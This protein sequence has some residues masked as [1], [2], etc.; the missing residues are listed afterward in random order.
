[1]WSVS[2]SWT[3]KITQVWTIHSKSPIK[4]NGKKLKKKKKKRR[5]FLPSL[6]FDQCI[7]S[8][9]IISNLLQEDMQLGLSPIPLGLEQVPGKCPLVSQ[10]HACACENHTRFTA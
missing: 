8:G 4:E 3:S 9:H 7:Q 1:M 5:N 10:S 2:L 6:L